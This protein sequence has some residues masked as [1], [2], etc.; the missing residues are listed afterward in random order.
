MMLLNS[1]GQFGR[2]SDQGRANGRQTVLASAKFA[3][4]AGD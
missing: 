1:V 4:K 3:L 2:V